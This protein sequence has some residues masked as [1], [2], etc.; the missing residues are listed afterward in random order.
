MKVRIKRYNPKKRKGIDLG[1]IIRHEKTAEAKDV[2]RDFE[3]TVE[4][5]VEKPE[6]VIEETAY[7]ANIY[8]TNEIYGYVSGGTRPHVIRVKN[9]QTLRFNTSGFKAKTRPRVIKSYAG[10]AARPPTAFPLEV[11]H[12]GTEAREFEKTIQKRSE[13]RFKSKIE[14]RIALEVRKQG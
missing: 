14:H 11:Q 4:T 1:K 7:G 9:A 12:P 3:A 5:W 2:K 13:K 8:T 10:K 6:F